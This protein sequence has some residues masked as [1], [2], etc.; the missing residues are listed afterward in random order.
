MIVAVMPAVSG[1]SSLPR[2]WHALWPMQDQRLAVQAQMAAP[3]RSSRALVDGE[4]LGRANRLAVAVLICATCVSFLLVCGILATVF[5]MVAL[6]EIEEAEEP[7]TGEGMAKWA[8]GL[9]FVNIVLSC[10]IIVL[11]ILVLKN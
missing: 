4:R 6:D 3:R 11:L 7:E 1:S 2:T 9:G 8:I 5:G 10:A